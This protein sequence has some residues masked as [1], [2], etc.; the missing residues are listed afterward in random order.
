M[1]IRSIYIDKYEFLEIDMGGAAAVFS[2]AKNNLDF[3]K[4]KDVGIKN[5]ENLKKWFELK[6][7]GYL[8]QVHGND[9]IVYKNKVEDGDA[10][11]TNEINNAVGVFTADCVPVILYDR[12]N[13]IIAAVHSGWKGTL[14]LIVKKAIRKLKNDYKSTEDDI[15][16][17]IGPNIQSCCYTV[18]EDVIDKFENSVFYRGKDIFI[19]NN[20]NL[21]KCIKYQLQSEK[22]KNENIKFIDVC[23]FCSSEYKM[24]SYRK[25][26]NCGRMFSFVYMK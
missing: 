24:H 13:R 4:S 26:K 5:I 21:K 18:G 25:D 20:L 11:F 10:I 8:N 6:S 14:N 17:C 12:K 1:D 23:T 2:T 9:L 16:V 22:I 15:F 3:N 7:I 19:K